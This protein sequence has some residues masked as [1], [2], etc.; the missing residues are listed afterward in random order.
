VI[1]TMPYR[2]I[3]L[4]GAPG[5]GKGTQGKIL[6]TIPGYYHCSCGEV[7]RRLRPETEL[8]R[9]FLQYS[10][11]GQLV[12]DEFTVRLWRENIAA[13]TQIG[14]YQPNHDTLVLDGIPRNPAQANVLADSVH[15]VAVFHLDCTNPQLLIQR[16]QRR[17]LKENRLDDANLDTIRKRFEVYAAETRKLLECYSSDII[18]RIDASQSPLQVLRQILAPL[19]VL[20]QPP[21]LTRHDHP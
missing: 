19:E 15:I 20:D 9:I 18:H 4:L 16:M 11:K 12:P 5:S 21:A 17:A 14:R 6:G 8:G 7:F 2:T 1:D 10:S 3:L 13:E